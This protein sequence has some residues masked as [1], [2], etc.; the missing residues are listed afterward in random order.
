MSEELFLNAKL[1]IDRAEKHLKD[2]Q[3]MQRCWFQ[4]NAYRFYI[5]P[6]RVAGS[7][8]YDI[9]FDN[10]FVADEFGVIIGDIIHNLRS[11][12]DVL[13]WELVGLD[14]GTQDAS[15]FFP[16]RKN[17]DD[18]KAFCQGLKTPNMASKALLEGF[19]AYPGGKGEKLHSLNRLSILDKHR[20]IVDTKT[21]CEI[22]KFI[23]YD[24]ETGEEEI[25]STIG[26]WLNPEGRGNVI[27]DEGGDDTKKGFRFDPQDGIWLHVV[28]AN[29][30][31]FPGNSILKVLR[32]LAKDVKNV[33]KAFMKH[34]S[35]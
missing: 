35:N 33:R 19:E 22:Y 5:T 4:G 6:D 23:I 25:Y 14:G 2:L 21:H 7:V 3:E 24:R 9:G 12:L 11:S 26:F 18:L 34:V 20:R 31:V 10:P 1:K 17:A 29:I 8:R 28:F 32:E 30:E 13:V 16:M 27:V 15:L